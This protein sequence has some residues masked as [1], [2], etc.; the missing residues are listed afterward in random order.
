MGKIP[1]QAKRVFRGVIYDVFQWPQTMFDGS[2][3]TFEMLKRPDNLSVIPVYE[4]KIVVAHEQQPHFRPWVGLLGGRRE[5][6]EDPLLGAQR[7]LREE[8]GLVS[9]DW[10]EL[11]VFDPV[12]SVDFKIRVFV[13]RGCHQVGEP[14]LD[15]GEK[16][17]LESVDFERFLEIVGSREFLGPEIAMHIMRMQLY[18]PAALAEFR[19]KL[20]Q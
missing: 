11:A 13:A 19:K 15:P 20:F 2:E 5:G 16:I 4:G 3:A 1:P 14:H 9:D 18:D 17:R 8:T 12:P 10:V 6:S 7:E